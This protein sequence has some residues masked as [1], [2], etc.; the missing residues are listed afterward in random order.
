MKDKRKLSWNHLEDSVISEN[1]VLMNYPWGKSG[2][3]NIYGGHKPEIIFAEPNTNLMYQQTYI[4][5][6]IGDL[7]IG[8]NVFINAV[9]G[10]VSENITEWKNKP[11]IEFNDNIVRAKMPSGDIVINL[12]K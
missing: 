6:L 12:D 1:G 5:T 11:E 3:V 10:N 4:P 7:E 9:Y 8:C 2:V